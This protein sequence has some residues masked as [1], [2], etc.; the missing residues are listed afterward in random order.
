[1]VQ[2]VWREISVSRVPQTYHLL[3]DIAA[4]LHSWYPHHHVLYVSVECH[5]QQHSYSCPPLPESLVW[6]STYTS[7]SFTGGGIWFKIHGKAKIKIEGP[8]EGKAVLYHWATYSYNFSITLY[9]YIMLQ[10]IDYNIYRTCC[11][12]DGSFCFVGSVLCWNHSSGIY[13]EM[14][15]HNI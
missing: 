10:S 5:H 6:R 13:V 15:Y 8:L 1:M 12:L 14:F 11:G 7:D 2:T 9:I 3:R 4:E